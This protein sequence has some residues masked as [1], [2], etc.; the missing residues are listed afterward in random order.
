LVPPTGYET[1]EHEFQVSPTSGHYFVFSYTLKSGVDLRGLGIVKAFDAGVLPLG[2]NSTIQDC[3]IVEFDEAGAVAHTWSASEHFDPVT[4]STYPQTGFGPNAKLPDGGTAYDVYHCNSIDVDPAN[5]NLLVS[6]RGMDSVFYVD[7]PS[8]KVR[9]K[10]GGADASLDNA[11]YVAV[12]DPFFRQHDARLQHGWAPACNG[13]SGQISVFDDETG[14]PG[15]A[16]A[17]IYDVIVG[18]SGDAGCPE[19]GAEGSATRGHATLAL[20]V[21]GGNVSG[22]GGSVRL[23]ADGSRVIGWGI[24]IPVFTEVTAKGATMLEFEFTAGDVSYRAIKV[25]VTAFDL[26]ALRNTAGM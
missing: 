11:T 26:T 1:D 2:Q 12:A 17:A 18:G 23:S 4:D 5:G 19:A 24:G 22:G 20:Q 10:M 16:R 3:T 21:K 6:A 8:G 7:W 13:G 9:W 25:P 14:M 15:P